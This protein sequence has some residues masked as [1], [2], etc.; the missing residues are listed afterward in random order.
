MSLQM[1]SEERHP[2]ESPPSHEVTKVEAT[3]VG[4]LYSNEDSGWSAVRCRSRS[5]DRFTA[6]GPLLGVI[7]GDE[8][9]LTARW[10]RHPKYG[11]QLEVT[12]YVHVQPSTLEGIKRFLGSGR[13]RGIGPKMAGRIV[14]AFGLDTLEV[15]EH[16]PERLREVRGVGS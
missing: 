4:V 2:L 13:I 15:I 16:E 6:V 11:E 12:S 9:R 7:E 3:V 1:M 14:R 8:L 5:G 10:Q